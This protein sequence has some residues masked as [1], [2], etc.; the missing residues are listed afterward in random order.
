MFKTMFAETARAAAQTRTTAQTRTSTHSAG[1][2]DPRRAGS[3][4]GGN[5]VA[6]FDRPQAPVP[7]SGGRYT[8]SF[9]GRVSSRPGRCVDSYVA[10]F[11]AAGHPA[12]NRRGSYVDA[13]R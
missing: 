6:V 1:G 3:A 8:A 11:G 7:A 2:A 10:A 13:E 9:D 4:L 5:Y 12:G